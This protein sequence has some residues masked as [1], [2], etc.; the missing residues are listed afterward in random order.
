M[1]STESGVVTGIKPSGS[2]HLGNYLG[3]IRPAL[4]LAE[5]FNAFYFIADLHA[6]TTVRDA[7]QLRQL[8]HE[9]TASWL[10]LGLD[11]TKVALYRQSDLPQVVELAWILSCVT[12][13]S[14]LNRAHAYKAATDANKDSDRDRDHGINAGLFSYPILMAAD[15]LGVGAG[16]VPVGL[17]QQQHLE[18]ARDIAESFN[19]L[20]AP[21]LT[22]PQAVIAPDVAT[23][24][25]V[26]ARKMSKTY[27][28]E[29]PIFGDPTAIRRSVMRIVT[30]SRKPEEP[31]DPETCTVFAIYR[32]FAPPDELERTRQR[33]LQ[34]GIAYSEVKESLFD[35]LQQHFREAQIRYRELIADSAHLDEILNEGAAQVA[36]LVGGINQVVRAA[37]GLPAEVADPIDMHPA[38]R[39]RRQN[40]R[41][42]LTPERQC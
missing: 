36:P 1:E 25:G 32:H 6:L 37:V 5:R 38:T 30:D 34:G 31:K 9:A 2:P 20:F 11:P 3:M 16:R 4:A 7:Q 17:D 22:I 26:D 19:S 18:I 8:S 39:A 27:N 41:W 23:I 33:Y 15:I 42:P 40:P 21:I 24:P 10:A 29:I 14:L 28:N 35:H 13:K 12:P